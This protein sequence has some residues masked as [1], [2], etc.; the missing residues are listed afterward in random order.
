MLFYLHISQIFCTFVPDSY[1]GEKYVLR[2]AFLKEKV[3]QRRTNSSQKQINSLQ[4]F[5]FAEMNNV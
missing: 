2:K 4:N 5:L 3:R 1:A